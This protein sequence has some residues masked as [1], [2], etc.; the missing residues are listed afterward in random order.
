MS[1]FKKWNTK[2]SSSKGK[3]KE[4][5]ENTTKPGDPDDDIDLPPSVRR[6]DRNLSISRSGRHKMRQRHRATIMND[7]LYS[8]EGATGR[9]KAADNNQGAASAQ[10]PAS[11]TS[12]NNGGYHCRETVDNTAGNLSGSQRMSRAP[13]AV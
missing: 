5:V 6:P 13:T 2:S 7:D 9:Q 1:F 4:N 12:G 11:K 8:P 3:E 10:A